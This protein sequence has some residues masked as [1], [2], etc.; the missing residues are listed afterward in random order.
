MNQDRWNAEFQS[1]LKAEAQTP[2]ARLSQTLRAKVRADLN[3]P[4]WSVFGKTA[5]VHL[6]VGAL[7]LIFCPQFG[8]GTSSHGMLHWLMQ[9]GEAV[10]SF[11]C[12]AFFLGSGALVTAFMLTPEQMRVMRRTEFPQ[13]ALLAVLFATAFFALGAQVAD[14]LGAIWLAGSVLG[15]LI[16]FELGRSTRRLLSSDRSA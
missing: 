4:L 11:G 14:L 13:Y 5:L 8:L 7:T 2:P 3:P 12:G 1:F 10:C 16:A 6:A 9:Y 15:G